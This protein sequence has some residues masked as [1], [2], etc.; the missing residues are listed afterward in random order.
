LRS[1]VENEHKQLIITGGEPTLHNDLF[2]LINYAKS[3]GFEK[4]QLQTNGRRLNDPSYLKSLIDE[5]IDEFGMSLHG[6][7][8]SIHDNV[9]KCA[10]SFSQTIS[11]IENLNFLFGANPPL[12]VNCVI[13]PEN[14]NSL[15]NFVEYMIALNVSTIKLSYL[16]GIGRAKPLLKRNL[17]PSMSE[18]QPFIIT[19][20]ETAQKMG[21]SNTTLTIE[22][23]PF[24]LL[25]GFENY[26]SDLNI[27]SVMVANKNGSFE[28][29]HS[30]M[31]RRKGFKCK[32][33][34]YNA[35]CLGPWKEYPEEFGWSELKPIKKKRS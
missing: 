35:E 21:K 16:H 26:S 33:C 29:Y 23:F 18:V 15:S 11:A 19:A 1:L 20:I 6:H 17:W 30:G 13:L 2:D 27:T 12:A 32:E 31:D 5:G 8:A 25:R 9:T 22:A 3:I 24:C 34:V 4:I 28:L 7:T 14:M 10:G